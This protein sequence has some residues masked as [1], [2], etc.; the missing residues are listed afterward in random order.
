MRW[1]VPVLAAVGAVACAP[2]ASSEPRPRGVQDAGPPPPAVDLR[3]APQPRLPP[4]PLPAPPPL[5][6]PGPAEEA[7]EPEQER[8]DLSAELRDALFG[9]QACFANAGREVPTT[10]SVLVTAHVT[11][12]GVVSRASVSASGAPDA[13]RRCV[14]ARA[15]AVRFRAP[16]PGA[17]R[18]VSATV[19]VHRAPPP[20]PP[21]EPERWQPSSGVPIT[22]VPGLEPSGPG[23][24]PITDVPGREPTGPDGV[25][26]TDVPGLEPSGPEGLP[27]SH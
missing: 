23:G 9:L 26:I 24:I 5:S 4:A 14:E 7:D 6:V 25:P 19:T 18:P 12:T 2:C 17:P 8:R 22:G 21:E 1:A 20:P 16:V 11:G 10:L 13:A 27:P 15:R 3:P